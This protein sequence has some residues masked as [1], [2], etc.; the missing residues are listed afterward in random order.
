MADLGPAWI[1]FLSG[2]VG[3]VLGMG[4]TAITMRSQLKLA[5]EERASTQQHDRESTRRAALIDYLVAIEAWRALI[6]S[7][8]ESKDGKFP[9]VED[10]RHLVLTRSSAAVD[11]LWGGAVDEATTGLHKALK[12]LEEYVVVQGRN[13]DV[14]CDQWKQLRKAALLARDEFLVQA[15][16]GL[17]DGR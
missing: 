8:A 4:G 5:R 3:G 9:G 2:A 10:D 13:A 11:L 16:R 1:A 17:L 15:R 12:A 14:G 6:E 7:H